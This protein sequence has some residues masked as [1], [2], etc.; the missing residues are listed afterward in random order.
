MQ[1]R[2]T[3]LYNHVKAFLEAPLKAL[4][5]A[6]SP[7]DRLLDTAGR[8]FHRHGFQAVGIDRILAESGVAKMTLYRH[9]PSKDALIAA[10]LSRA[11]AE[12]WAWAEKA[13]ARARSPEGRLLALFEAIESLAA[14]RECLGCVFQGAVMAFPEHQH[15]GHQVA[16]RHK[17]AV[18][19]RLSALAAAAGLRDPDRLAAQLA[20]LIDGAW[21]G[22][23]TFEAADSPAVGLT[24]AA[25]A[26][27]RAQRPSP[28]RA[29]KSR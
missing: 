19:Q 26:I 11:D 25:R 27:L 2:L 28:R 3:G 8:L 23:R 14:S 13:M 10:Y 4:K 16:A 15:S 9:F 22:A 1:R 18:R 17:K 12:F 20:L 21:I 29:P 7:R 24:D 6:G 5:G